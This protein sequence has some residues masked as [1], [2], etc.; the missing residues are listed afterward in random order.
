[1]FRTEIAVFIPFCLIDQRDPRSCVAFRVCHEPSIFED[2]LASRMLLLILFHFRSSFYTDSAYSLQ[3]A[4]LILCSRKA[5]FACTVIN[6]VSLSLYQV[7]AEPRS[8]KAHA[9]R[10]KQQPEPIENEETDVSVSSFF[11]GDAAAFASVSDRRN[12]VRD[13]WKHVCAWLLRVRIGTG[14]GIGL[15]IIGVAGSYDIALTALH[16][17][18]V[19]DKLLSIEITEYLIRRNEP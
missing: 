13:D 5:S 16:F 14:R 11:T 4:Q 19:D 8:F 2:A 9:P 7:F 6:A 10:H 12:H 18:F 15:S 1:M 3:R 17:S